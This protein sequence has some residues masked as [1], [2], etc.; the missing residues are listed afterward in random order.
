LVQGR[1]TWRIGSVEALSNPFLKADSRASRGGVSFIVKKLRQYLH[2]ETALPGV[3]IDAVDSLQTL[4]AENDIQTIAT[5]QQV[6]ELRLLAE[7]GYIKVTDDIQS[8]VHTAVIA[9]AIG[10]YD[11]SLDGVITKGIERASQ[12]SHL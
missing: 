1:S 4:S 2:G 5:H 8:L 3:F 6:F 10:G 7:L 12:V 11:T 9:D